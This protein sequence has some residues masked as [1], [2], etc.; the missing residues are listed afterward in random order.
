[1]CKRK[2]TSVVSGLGLQE[3]I[4]CT[5]CHRNVI[6]QSHATSSAAEYEVAR[7]SPTTMAVVLVLGCA[8]IKRTLEAGADGESGGRGALFEEDADEEVYGKDV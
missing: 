7:G 6:I 8:A 2:S 5:T 3:Q 1:M 4:L